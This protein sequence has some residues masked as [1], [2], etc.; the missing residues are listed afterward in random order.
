MYELELL[1]ICREIDLPVVGK[2]V[3]FLKYTTFFDLFL[4]GYLLFLVSLTTRVVL[5]ML[6]SDI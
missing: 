1:R 3:Q 6:R 4:L 5:I 2:L